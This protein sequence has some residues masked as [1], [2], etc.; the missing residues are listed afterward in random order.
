MKRFFAA[1]IC[2]ALLPLCALAGDDVIG[3][4]QTDPVMQEAIA[5]AR[6]SLPQFLA[7]SLGSNGQSVDGA[8][9]KVEFETG[10]NESEVIWI[11]PFAPR[12]DGFVGILA[13]EPNHMPGQHAGDMVEFSEDQISDWTYS[14]NGKLY[15]NYTT[16][17]MLPQLDD[18]TRTQLEQMM[19]Q[20]PVPENW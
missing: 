14:A 18:A 2:A 8:G 15:G 12:G 11:V 6:T 17:V 13:N 20:N 5:D 7:N 4:G 10:D 1:A 3:F 9:L 19:S 16:R